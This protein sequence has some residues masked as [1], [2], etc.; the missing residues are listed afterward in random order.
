[1]ENKAHYALIGLF[2]LLSMIAAL[3]FM[4]W[5]SNAQ[6]DQQFDEYEV[7]FSG[8]VRGLSQGSEV[9]F[10]GLKVGEVLGLRLDPK[11]T[12]TVLAEI[13]VIADT[14][15]DTKSYARLEPLG[16]T[17]LSYIQIF[18]GG[19]EFPL[20]KD[21]PGK[22][23]KRIEGQM[24]QLDT[25]LDGGGS[26]IES[27][28][29]ALNAV[30]VVLSEDAVED[31]H[32]I[33]ENIQRITA[34][35]NTSELD[36]EQINGMFA[37]VAQAADRIAVTAESITGTSNSLKGV[38][39][40]DVKELLARTEQ[41]LDNLDTAL[42]SYDSLAIESNELVV[43]TRDAINRLSNSGL[44]DLEETV[45]AIRRLV[46][47]LGRVADG[48]EQNPSQFIVGSERETVDIPQ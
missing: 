36:M 33:L 21:L 4:A 34:D 15:V 23:P 25:F 3:A 40:K 17:G 16:L 45:D 18:S 32:Q 11:D 19:E 47:T 43:D 24:S 20:L 7:S 39:D 5:L 26:V 46:E 10:N 41:S 9:R 28:G 35:L 8:P 22:G 31:F 30:N 48:L 2:V 12:N 6:F 44:T 42:A 13:Q 37:S 1:M 14:P 27:A 38:V 29:R